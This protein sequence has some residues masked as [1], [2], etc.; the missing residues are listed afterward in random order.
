MKHTIAALFLAVS[1]LALPAVAQDGVA[2]NGLY[3][4][5]RG[6]VSQAPDLARFTFEVVRQGSDAAA[7]KREVDATTAA[8][9]ALA[10]RLG[11][12]RK[13]V[14]AAVIQVRPEYRYVDGRS[15]LEGVNVSRTIAVILRDLERYGELST[16][17]IDAGV[18][19]ILGVS[20]DIDDRAAVER[21][22]LDDALT[23]A[24]DEANHVAAR[25]GMKLGRVLEVHVDDVGPTPVPM[26]AAM[27]MR[28]K[29]GD[30]F[31]PGEIE[32][33][34]QVRLRYELELR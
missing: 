18:N 14:T 32:V 5:G 8:V 12:A 27:A 29:S 10:E 25:L 9:V 7:L 16:G 34:R 1:A 26:V 31:R 21:K 33:S 15:L 4:S 20:L 2:Q 23:N 13:D 24:A 17:A 28:E 19:Q 22:A 3:V 30:D 6:S 11:V